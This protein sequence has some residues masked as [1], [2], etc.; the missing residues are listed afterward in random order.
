MIVMSHSDRNF[1]ITLDIETVISGA[2]GTDTVTISAT[3]LQVDVSGEP[4]AVYIVNGIP[5]PSI[6][7]NEVW[8]LV[9]YDPGEWGVIDGDDARFAR[10]GD[11]LT[12]LAE[13]AGPAAQKI[14]SLGYNGLVDELS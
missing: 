5:V 4:K 2:I 1:L 6:G 10:F 7:S 12:A 8:F 13:T 9:E 3:G 14:E 11:T